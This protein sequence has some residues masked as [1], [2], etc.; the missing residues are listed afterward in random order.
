MGEI[1]EFKKEK[2]IIILEVDIIEGFKILFKSLTI[3]TKRQNKLK[4][5]S[6]CALWCS[7][8][9]NLFRSSSGDVVLAGTSVSWRILAIRDATLLSFFVP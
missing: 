4:H 8:E 9:W 5:H 2:R 7:T 1:T 6:L 3:C